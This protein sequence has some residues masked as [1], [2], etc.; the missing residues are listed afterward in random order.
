MLKTAETVSIGHPDKTAD[1]I[2][3]YILDRFIEQ[4]PNVRYAVEVMIKGNTVILG[5][6]ITTCAPFSNFDAYVKQALRE[7]GYDENYH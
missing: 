7:I 1:Y 3:S 6:E 5:G 2:S 4:D